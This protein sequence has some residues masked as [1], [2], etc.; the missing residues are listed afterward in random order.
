MSAIV[1]PPDDGGGIDTIW[2]PRYVTPTG[3]RHFGSYP[4]R[5]LAVMMPLPRLISATSSDA[6]SPL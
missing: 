1:S 5:S 2:W 4:S 3:V 6:V